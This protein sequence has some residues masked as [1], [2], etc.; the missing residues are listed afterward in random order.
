MHSDLQRDGRGR[1]DLKPGGVACDSRARAVLVSADLLERARTF[2][3]A[4]E[5]HPDRRV[6][7]RSS[8]AGH[9]RNGPSSGDA[10]KCRMDM[11]ER[12]GEVAGPVAAERGRGLGVGGKQLGCDRGRCGYRRRE[13]AP[14]RRSVWAVDPEHQ[15]RVRHCS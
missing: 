9:G 10:G 14:R 3:E 7:L 4:P 13:P 5:P 2:A 1:Q 15:P 8:R 12:S 11:R 6:G